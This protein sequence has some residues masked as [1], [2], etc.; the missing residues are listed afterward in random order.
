MGLGSS[1]TSGFGATRSSILQELTERPFDLLVL[2][3][4]A[5]GAGIALEAAAQGIR[6]ALIERGD[7]AGG[8]SSRSTKLIHGGVRYLERAFLDWDIGQYRLV[9]EALE[10]R[11]LLL[12]NAP[13][14]TRWLPILTP[15][16]RWTDIPYFTAG[17][18]LY[19][20]LAGRHEKR[21]SELL[22]AKAALEK[23]PMLQKKNLCGAVLYYDGQFDDARMNI[24]IVLKSV[25]MGAVA[26]NYVT[27]D[28]FRFKDG[29]VCGVEARDHWTG[30]PLTITAKRIINA[31]G[32]Y[33]DGVRELSDPGIPKMLTASSGTHIVLPRHFSA[34]TAGILIPKTSD[35]RVLFLLPWLGHTVA[36]TTDMP[37][38]IVDAPR[39]TDE[40]VQYILATLRR[41]LSME[42]RHSDI[43]SQWSGLRPLVSPASAKTNT[44]KI[45]RE[46]LI[47][48]SKSG[49]VTVTG[50]KWTTYR[51]M[52]EEA[53]SV[54]MEGTGIPLRAGATQNIRLYGAENLHAD[55][56]ARLQQAF[57]FDHEQAQY[58]HRAYG[59]HAWKVAEFSARMN[60]APLVQGQGQPHLLAE[61]GYATQFEMAQSSSDVLA[62]R[63]RLAFVDAKAARAALPV[64]QEELRKNLGWDQARMDLDRMQTEVS[65]QTEFALS[66]PKQPP[67]SRV[68]P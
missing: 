51:R 26:A 57:G 29:K 60:H 20:W 6:V 49:L 61:V 19:G 7:F 44:A 34:R 3:G 15:L 31:T 56:I 9:T 39:P 48:T 68:S 11:T 33:A 5:T 21:T 66:S 13:H 59:S 27:L 58:L 38:P 1:G 2:G 14:L 28:R 4:G 25:E 46:H 18:K 42:I 16:Y 32:P 63:L 35:G 40:D 17:L 62:R 23:C 64:V 55:N 12:Q 50:G 54:C 45:S 37:S 41:Y 52:A 36:G 53:L 43:L 22:S 47:E 65:L 67:A 10:E 30:R 8:T 24:S